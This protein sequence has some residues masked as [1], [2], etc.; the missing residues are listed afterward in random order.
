[1]VGKHTTNNIK[2]SE[3]LVRKASFV[4]SSKIVKPIFENLC[5]YGLEK[6]IAFIYKGRNMDVDV[7]AP[8][9]EV[10]MKS[11]QEDIDSIIFLLKKQGIPIPQDVR[12]HQLD[13]QK[14]IELKQSICYFENW[15]LGYM[16]YLDLD[17]LTIDSVYY[18][19]R[20][21]FLVKFEGLDMIVDNTPELPINVY[22]SVG[23]K[24]KTVKKESQ[25]EHLSKHFTFKT[26]KKPLVGTPDEWKASSAGYQWVQV[27]LKMGRPRKEIIQEFNLKHKDDPENY[28]SRE[29]KELTA[30][31]LSH[32]ANDN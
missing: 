1:M 31:I 24:K 27:Q 28:S 26:K 20:T 3:E 32:W 14:R 4:Q 25:K 21:G 17:G 15:L 9:F 19:H 22:N 2:V 6:E 8:I 30:A 5:M 29:G 11:K 10:G 12:T 7:L 23:S 18:S 13:L 16:V